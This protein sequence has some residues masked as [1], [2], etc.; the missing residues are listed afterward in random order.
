MAA[1]A[2]NSAVVSATR[3]TSAPAPCSSSSWIASWSRS[4]ST[5]GPSGMAGTSVCILPNTLQR[6]VQPGE[7]LQRQLLCP[8]VGIDPA[9]LHGADQRGAIEVGQVIDQLLAPHAEG[10]ADQI[11]QCL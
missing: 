1:I 3:R 4:V 7:L 11:E 8:R 10:G 9:P 2:A 6:R 5:S